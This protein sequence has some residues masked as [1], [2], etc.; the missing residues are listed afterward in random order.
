MVVFC[1]VNESVYVVG[2][3]RWALD[4][5]VRPICREASGVP[6][7]AATAGVADAPFATVEIA[8]AQGARCI[9]IRDSQRLCKFVRPVRKH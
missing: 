2:H 7:F 5:D 8:I 1:F 9:A 3:V 6:T 4:V